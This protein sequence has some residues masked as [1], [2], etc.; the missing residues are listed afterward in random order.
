MVRRRCRS[1]RSAKGSRGKAHFEGASQWY[2][3]FGLVSNLKLAARLDRPLRGPNDLWNR[4][5]HGSDLPGQLHLP[6]TR[7]GCGRTYPY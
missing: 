7:V 4:T 3:S 6:M 5:R 2:L 1:Q